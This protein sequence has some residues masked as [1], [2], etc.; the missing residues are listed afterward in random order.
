MP[1]QAVTRQ[2]AYRTGTGHD[3]HTGQEQADMT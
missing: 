1:D 2:A 3:M